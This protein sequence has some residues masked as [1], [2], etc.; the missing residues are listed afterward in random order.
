MELPDGTRSEV[1]SLSREPL[2]ECKHTEEN[3]CHFT[4][5]TKFQSVS[6]QGR[7][8]FDR[9]RK[10]IQTLCYQESKMKLFSQNTILYSLQ[11]CEEIFEKKCQITFNQEARNETVKMCHRPMEIRCDGRVNNRVYDDD[12]DTCR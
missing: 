4:Y 5:V 11:V 12:E 2:L 7:A 6:E 3:T 8:G 10:D 1:Q 9:R